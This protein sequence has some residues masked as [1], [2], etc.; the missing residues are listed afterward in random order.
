MS[1]KS[2]PIPAQTD[3]ERKDK[4]NYNELPFYFSQAASDSAD[5]NPLIWLVFI[6]PSHL[7][8][9]NER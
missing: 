3:L 4:I 6:T 9:N 7:K 2:D 5:I 8:N 1:P